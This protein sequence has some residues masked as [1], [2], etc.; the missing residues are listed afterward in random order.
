MTVC[1]RLQRRRLRAPEEDRAAFVEPPLDEVGA[2]LNSNVNCRD[3]Y[4]YD[5][6]GRSLAELSRQARREL[7]GEARRWTAAYRDIDDRDV[8]DRR[9]D[10]PELIFLAGHQPELFHPGVW[11]KS[12]ALDGL[13]ARHGATAI[14]L[15]IDTDVVTRHTV[16][17]PGGSIAEPHV[18]DIPLDRS[19]EPVPF[20]ER[21]IAERSLFADFGRRAAE[22]I[23]SLVPDPLVHDYWP[24][25]VG[26][27]E[28][29]DNLGECLAQSRH[30]LEGRWGLTTLE[31]PQSR[32]AGTESH[33]WF[34]AHL[35]AQLPRLWEIY[36][37]VVGEY[38]R[39]NRIRS[40]S[41][42]V[43]DLAADG[44]WLEAPFWI[45]T[46]D[47]PRR[48]RLFVR[49]RRAQIILSDRHAL[50]IGL[51]LEPDGDVAKAAVRLAELGRRGVKIRCRALI[52][53]LWA[54]LVLGD[55]FIHGIGGAKYDQVTD[56]LIDRFFGL[57]PPG[58]LVVSAT[59]LLPIVRRGVT[60]EEYRAI[61]H[62]LRELVYHPER[63]VD[64]RGADPQGSTQ[65][66]AELIAAKARWVRTKPTKHNARRRC[67]G[68]RRINQALQPWVAARRQGLLE[69]RRQIA[70]G[71]Q[72]Q[73]V[74]SSREY[75]FCLYP[76]KTL[77]DFLSGLLPKDA[78]ILFDRH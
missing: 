51:P 29:T 13:A 76:E 35:L 21:R 69:Q 54:R 14:N 71:L 16:R 60:K 42:P 63:Y 73:S 9:V 5:F 3:E 11:L 44:D 10:S 24:L 58:F 17:V 31:V 59:L 34:V 30:Q 49:Y 37:E 23:A 39:A 4:S 28:Q 66:P 53:T 64:P 25:A 8:D 26:R 72:A 75:G 45:W 38:R 12:F 6:Q 67:R 7:L 61:E 57:K 56:A 68:I 19:T 1:Q 55:L 74:L 47:D 70:G 40:K 15:T 33:G 18:R 36:N 48:R 27:M 2:M 78:G 43:P 20:E 22:Q 32:L 77:R 62:E 50:H 41:H 65:H 46:V 52:T